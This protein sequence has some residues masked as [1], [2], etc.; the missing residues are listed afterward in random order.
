MTSEDL[1]NAAEVEDRREESDGAFRCPDCGGALVEGTRGLNCASCTKAYPIRDGIVRFVTATDL[2]GRDASFTKVYD[3]WGRFYD[4]SAKVWAGLFHGGD[5]RFRGDVASS[6]EISR[7]YR[8]LETSI[9]TGGNIPYIGSFSCDLDIY[10]LDISAGMLDKCRKNLKKWGIAA[11]LC[12]ANAAALPFE[13]DYFDCVYHLGGI[14]GF[15]DR[16]RAISEMVRVAKPG[17][18]VVISDETPK[19]CYSVALRSIDLDPPVDMI[20][21]GVEE[22]DQREAVDGTMWVIKFRKPA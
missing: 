4:V 21:E 10:G 5:T 8:V 3:L 7:G 16:E 13:D 17:T 22:L 12:Q 11:R 18:V 19:M 15:S 1:K 2:A 20:P 14:N 6:L 9:G